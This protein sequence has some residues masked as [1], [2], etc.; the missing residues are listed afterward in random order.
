MRGFGEY[1]GGTNVGQLVSGEAS[2]RNALGMGD[3]PQITGSSPVP[4]SELVGN[5]TF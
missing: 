1:L 4:V 3:Y 2:F 5:E